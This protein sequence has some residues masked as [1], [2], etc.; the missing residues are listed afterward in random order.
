MDALAS[1]TYSRLAG[2]R[3]DDGLR[4]TL[5]TLAEDE[6]SHAA[7]WEDL[8]EAWENGLLPDILNEPALRYPIGTQITKP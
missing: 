8:L 5:E 7:W 2:S 1:D 4:A 3:E 6:K